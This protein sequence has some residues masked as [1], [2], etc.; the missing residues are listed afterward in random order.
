MT[1]AGA[2]V[3]PSA[4]MLLPEYV[5]A[6]DPAAPIRDRCVDA[7][8]AGLLA[9]PDEVVL[10]AGHDRAP[11]HTKGA[12]GA[13]I[14]RR[15]LYAA[16]WTGPTHEVVVPFDASVDEVAAAVADVVRRP[17]RVLLVVVGDGS[18]KRTEK[19]PGHL[20]ERA[21]AVDGII[22]DAL[23]QADSA[24]LANLDD[25][26]CAQLWVTGRAA[27]QVLGEACAGVAMRP[28]TMWFGDPYGVAYFV[29]RWS[30]E[31]ATDE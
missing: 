28:E 6:A 5:G 31:P 21:P 9:G 3:L 27:L 19:A 25:D 24:A 13:R 1:V 20:D 23:A 29:A 7:V 8:R 12:L 4:A 15:A 22:E 16:G 11:R 17:G 26:L 14:G 10:V 2:V 18:A 30:A